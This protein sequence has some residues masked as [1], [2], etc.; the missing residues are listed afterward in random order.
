MGQYENKVH[1]SNNCHSVCSVPSP[2]FQM[3][4]NYSTQSNV[5]THTP[6]TLSLSPLSDSNYGQPLSNVPVADTSNS[7]YSHDTSPSPSQSHSLHAEPLN[8]SQPNNSLTHFQD[9]K[10]I[11]CC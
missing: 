7:E 1:A 4:Q 11:D 5:Y 3:H 10:L 6:P 2:Q 9:K 8:V